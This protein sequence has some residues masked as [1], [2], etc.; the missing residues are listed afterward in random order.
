MGQVIGNGN[1]RESVSILYVSLIPRLISSS[2]QEPGDFPLIP[3]SA[4]LTTRCVHYV[5]HFFFWWLAKLYSEILFKVTV[6]LGGGM[7][8]MFVVLWYPHQAAERSEDVS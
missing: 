6:N 1:I 2:T 5:V 4:L 7:G 8:Y 3:L